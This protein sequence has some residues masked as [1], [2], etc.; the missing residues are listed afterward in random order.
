MKLDDYRLEDF[1]R[2][3]YRD[4]LIPVNILMVLIG[5]CILLFNKAVEFW[6]DPIRVS[7]VV[8]GASYMIAYMFYLT[9]YYEK[10]WSQYYALPSDKMFFRMYSL[11]IGITIITFMQNFPEYWYLY[12]LS[13]LVV[14]YIK[15]RNTRMAFQNAFKMQYNEFRKCEDNKVKAQY[16][17]SE[18]F[19]VNFFKYGVIFNILYSVALFI[20]MAANDGWHSF[21]V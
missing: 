17:L 15:K 8:C 10:L 2:S 5:F 18:A 3:E 21:C 9:E 19:T 13:L 7:S 4:S 11:L 20:S 14:M 1:G 12:T 16:V 6:S